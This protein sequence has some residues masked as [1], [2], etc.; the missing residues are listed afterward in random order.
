GQNLEKVGLIGH[1]GVVTDEVPPA[2]PEA[3]R[4]VVR[5]YVCAVHTTY[6]DH[7]R[8][9]PPG[10]RAAL[11]V[12]AA[13]ELTVVA[14]ATRRLHLVATTDPLPA[15][16]GPEVAVTDEKDGLT[17]TVRFYDPSVLPELGLLAADSPA[18]VRRALGI[19]NTVYHLSVDVGGG[20]SGHNA[21]HSGV[22]LANQHAKL[23]RD[24]DRL[25][26]GVPH[27]AGVVDEFAACVRNGLDRAAALLAAELT[28]GR[29]VPEAGTPAVSCLEA[30]LDDLIR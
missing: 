8:Q 3:M 11:P 29:V 28:A 19:S 10:E 21:Q 9:L 18:E 14:A 1:S 2:R 16:R 4:D 20:L 23:S 15:P 7:V 25:R 24:L 13:T 22:A 6:L 30:V 12:V 26:H 5:D 17:W 27:Q